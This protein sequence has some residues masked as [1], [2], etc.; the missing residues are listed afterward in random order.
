[1]N[2]RVGCIGLGLAALAITGC[3]AINPGVGPDPGS[4]IVSSNSTG[5]AAVCAG[6]IAIDAA[7]YAGW[8]GACPGCDIDAQGLYA[9]SR[10][11]GA[12]SRL[13]LNSGATIAKWKAAITAAATPLKRGNLLIITLS[14][15]GGQIPDDNG[16]E[17]DGL[18]ETSCL[19]D[20]QLRDDDFLALLTTL[21]HGLR[22]LII[23]DQCHSQGNFMLTRFTA[24]LVNRG[25]P[26]LDSTEGS[27]FDGEIIQLAGCREESYSYGG[28]QG[29]VW[30]TTFL[31]WRDC[32]MTLAEWFEQAKKEMP[33]NQIPVWVEYGAVSDEFRNLVL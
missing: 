17:A 12:S 30:T 33:D 27:G 11:I 5:R 14:G 21:P 22:I 8:D 2:I 18:D 10:D 31:K 29:G 6:W 19:W 7:S 25:K 26:A 24:S 4:A 28:D 13:M 16:D 32:G 3:A 23:S 1:M 15:H 20:G 9:W